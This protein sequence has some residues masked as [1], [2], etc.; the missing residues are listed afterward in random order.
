MLNRKF[1]ENKKKVENRWDIDMTAESIKKESLKAKIE[2]QQDEK[3]Q[4]MYQDHADREMSAQINKE[5]RKQFRKDQAV[6]TERQH[7]K[8]KHI[9]E[10][11]TELIQQKIT[12]NKA[13]YDKWKI[14]KA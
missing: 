6:K 7:A 14:S 3:V 12:K 8:M 13:F 11:Q 10:K 9:Y 2:R 1:K 4:K 5:Q